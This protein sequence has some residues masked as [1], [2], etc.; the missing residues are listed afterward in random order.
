[1]PKYRVAMH[2]GASLFIVVEANDETEAADIAYEEIP[3]GVCAQCSGWGQ[4]WSL[5]LGD[6]EIDE[7]EEF[8]GTLY[9]GVEP[10]EDE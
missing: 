8:N 1:M 6:L 4:K 10:V 5:D 3:G 9:K 2:T 7:D